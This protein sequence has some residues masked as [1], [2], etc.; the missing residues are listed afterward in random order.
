M[1]YAARTDLVSRYGSY[2]VDAAA[3][4]PV[5]EGD[6]D[7]AVAA[8]ADASAR[9]DQAL[10][11]VYALPLPDR[12][13]PILRSIAARLAWLYL[14]DD[15]AP[16]RVKSAATRARRDLDHVLRG[17]LVATGGELAPRLPQ[18]QATAP[19]PALTRDALDFV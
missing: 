2:D 9:I 3:P 11:T 5:D 7:L 18:A 19:E 8:L 14:H 13:W 6:P 12:D 10:G 1:T 15:E 4:A 16:D 17:V